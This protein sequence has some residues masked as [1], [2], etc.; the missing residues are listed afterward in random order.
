[1]WGGG[2]VQ[3]GMG[4]GGSGDGPLCGPVVTSGSRGAVGAQQVLKCQSFSDFPPKKYHLHNKKHHILLKLVS[5]PLI[6]N[7]HLFSH[8][9]LHAHYC[10]GSYWNVAASIPD[11]YI[12]NPN[13]NMS[14]IKE[15]PWSGT[16]I[17]EVHLNMKNT[18]TVIVQY[19]RLYE[20]ILIGR[21]I[22]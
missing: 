20:A 14:M 21:A 16:D 22:V 4:Q 3:C 15:R 17:Q 13:H 12:E 10:S 8:S 19:L 2:N 5:C 18:F 11:S 6:N 9:F 1:M 7:P